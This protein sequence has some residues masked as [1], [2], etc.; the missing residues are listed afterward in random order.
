MKNKFLKILV[1]VISLF[2][3]SSFVKASRQTLDSPVVLSDGKIQI[4]IRYAMYGL[5]K[6]DDMVG[7]DAEG[8]KFLKDYGAG[9]LPNASIDPVFSAAD[10]NDK[11]LNF[12]NLNLEVGES[13]EDKFREIL[14][15]DELE[16]DYIVAVMVSYLV[17]SYPGFQKLYYYNMIDVTNNIPTKSYD[18]LI[19]VKESS[20]RI[21]QAVMLGKYTSSTDSFVLYNTAEQIRNIADL[22]MMLNF[23]ILSNKDSAFYDPSNETAKDQFYLLHSL[24]NHS[25]LL[26]Q[27]RTNYIS[28]SPSLIAKNTTSNSAEISVVMNHTPKGQ[29]CKL[30][31]GTSA[32][33]PFEVL[34]TVDCATISLRDPVEDQNPDISFLD[35]NLT[36][37][38]TYY[39]R[40]VPV[41]GSVYSDVA[42]IKTLSI[43]DDE[44]STAPIPDSPKTGAYVPY[45]VVMVALSMA[46]AI[47]AYLQKKKRLFKI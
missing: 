41:N 10:L 12:L 20:D 43:E 3:F 6:V 26:N 9:I 24:N 44:T 22:N 47:G 4:E 14:D 25:G 28:P 2:G 7:T 15:A 38:T 13:M 21:A 16:G 29:M 33:G 1:L 23:S 27:Y 11:T 35:K 45:L 36:A 39:Y 32:T 31:R 34:G 30:E 40:A 5:Y 46:I 37:N 42:S 17:T 18:D 8:F 19:P